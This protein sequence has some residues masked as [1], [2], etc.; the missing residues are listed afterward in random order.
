MDPKE[1]K[2]KIKLR[3]KKGCRKEHWMT[4]LYFLPPAICLMGVILVASYSMFLSFALLFFILPMLYTVEKRIRISI[5]GI[6]SMKFSYK[7]GYRGFF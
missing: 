7:D 2:E 3:R 5:S 6:G 1:L 4:L